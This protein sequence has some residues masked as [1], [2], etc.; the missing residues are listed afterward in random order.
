MKTILDSEKLEGISQSTNVDG[1]DSKEYT[2]N[3]LV[4]LG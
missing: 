3:L 4:A 2:K 1:I